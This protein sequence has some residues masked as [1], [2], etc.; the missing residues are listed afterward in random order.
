MVSGLIVLSFIIFI[1]FHAET[2]HF[3]LF[4]YCCKWAGPILFE[5]K[6]KDY[7]VLGRENQYLNTN[8]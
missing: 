7:G 8:M 6:I 5:K 1:T 2:R 3:F 4:T